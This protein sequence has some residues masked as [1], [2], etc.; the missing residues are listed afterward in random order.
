MSVRLESHHDITWLLSFCLTEVKR[1]PSYSQRNVGE[2]KGQP[3]TPPLPCLPSMVPG[4][5]MLW[6][7][8]SC[9]PSPNTHSVIELPYAALKW[10]GHLRVHMSVWKSYHP[11]FDFWGVSWDGFQGMSLHLCWF[12]TSE[13]CCAFYFLS[14][15]F[16]P[17]SLFPPLFTSPI[18]PIRYWN[19]CITLNY[20][21][22]IDV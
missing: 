15:S 13:G 14:N 21:F 10:C 3:K 4:P 6:A 12:H 20:S 5:F 1:K 2:R 16:L 7:A 19:L 8:I 11:P 17:P 18:T 22:S 9:P